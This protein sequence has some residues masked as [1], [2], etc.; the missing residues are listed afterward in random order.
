MSLYYF[1]LQY[2]HVI[3]ATV[4]L[5]TGAGI[6]F[7]MLRAHLNGDPVVVAGVARIVVTADFVFTATAV[8][9]QPITGYLLARFL[10][11]PIFDGWIALSLMLLAIPKSVIFSRP[12]RV[13]MRLAGLRSRC[14]TL[15]CV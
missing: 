4:L 8:V 15:G 2:L 14:T 9:V 12:S 6:A 3:G 7:F 13:T 1:A 10:G 5:G 11:Y